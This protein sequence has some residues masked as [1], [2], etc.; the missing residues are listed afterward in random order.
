MRHED[1]LGDRDRVRRVARRDHLPVRRSAP[2]CLNA[3]IIAAVVFVAALAF[4]LWLVARAWAAPEPEPWSAT[5]RPTGFDPRK[6]GAIRW[7]WLTEREARK[8][9]A[10]STPAR[11]GS[12][13]PASEAGDARGS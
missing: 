13:A 6:H 10:H 8:P 2:F 1:H 4:W 11:P 5:R 3:A 9:G 7:F 12:S